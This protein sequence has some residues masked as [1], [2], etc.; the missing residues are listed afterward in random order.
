LSPNSALRTVDFPTLV[1]HLRKGQNEITKR[2]ERSRPHS[3]PILVRIPYLTYPTKATLM[4]KVYV[5]IAVDCPKDVI[6]NSV[7]VQTI[8]GLLCIPV[9]D[10]N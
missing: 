9:Y 10:E 4:S 8:I 1:E 5:F 3:I 7:F 6:E 2:L